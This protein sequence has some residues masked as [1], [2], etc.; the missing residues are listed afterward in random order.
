MRTAEVLEEGGIS[1]ISI[2]GMALS[3]ISSETTMT[4]NWLFPLNTPHS[5]LLYDFF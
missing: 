1:L 4:F 3:G 5:S 2:M